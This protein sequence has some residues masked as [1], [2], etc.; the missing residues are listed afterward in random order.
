MN[1]ITAPA[2]S[3]AS[4]TSSSRFELLA[5]QVKARTNGPVAKAF[6][7][8]FARIYDRID[9]QETPPGQFA[10]YANDAGAQPFYRLWRP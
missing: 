5:Q 7:L 4:A 6:T 10:A 3:I 1:T 9:E 2:A 8:D